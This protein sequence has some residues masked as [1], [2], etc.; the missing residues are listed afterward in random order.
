[1]YSCFSISLTVYVLSLHSDHRESYQCGHQC[2]CGRVHGDDHARDHGHARVHGRDHGDDVHLGESQHVN[3][4][5]IRYH[6]TYD[7]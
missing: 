5:G 3:G 6:Y 1:M 2:G 4:L 7:R